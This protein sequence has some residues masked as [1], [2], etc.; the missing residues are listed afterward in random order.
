M[1]CKVSSYR[2][3]GGMT[4]STISVN[5]NDTADKTVFT[6]TEKCVLKLSTARK[7]SAS[8]E[9]T[10]K[11]NSTN[12]G[13]YDSYTGT[14]KGMS[15]SLA[16]VLSPIGMSGTSDADPSALILYL[17]EGDTVYATRTSGNAFTLSLYSAVFTF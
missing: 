9:A 11:L 12:I 1:G 5:F 2:V 6:A 8:N 16:N 3:G 13:N 15:R 14:F 17:E 4:S 10:F 7:M